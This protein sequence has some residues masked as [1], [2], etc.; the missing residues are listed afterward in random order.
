MKSG[1]AQLFHETALEPLPSHAAHDSHLGAT[2]DAGAVAS[3]LRRYSE[4]PNTFNSNRKEAERFLLWLSERRLT[5]DAI[6]V[7]DLLDYVAFLQAPE[8]AERWIGPSKPRYVGGEP[9]PLWRPF[10]GPLGASSVKLATTILFGLFEY[11]VTASYLRANLWRLLPKRKASRNRELERYLPHAARDAV[12]EY[13]R[14][15]VNQAEDGAEPRDFRNQWLIT[16]FY[17]SGA[18]RSE[19]ANARMSHVFRDDT[20]WWWKIYGKGG[21]IDEVPLSAEFIDQLTT[22]RLSVGLSPLPNPLEVS[23]PLV[24]DV[25][26]AQRP[27]GA[28]SVY[29]LIKEICLAASELASDPYVKATLQLASPHWLRHT[30]ASDQLNQAK[31]GLAAVSR[32]L[33]HSDIAIT[34]RY[35]HTDRATRHEETQRHI[36]P[37]TD[38]R[39]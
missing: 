8:P 23:I 36:L 35:L 5:L 25:Y 11:L 21:V 38:E 4:S 33:R 22:Y 12:F 26:G 16:V 28:S 3:W 15:R 1:F 24:G 30:A 17:L 2:D 27:L 34:S 7:E 6:R 31:L 13:V 29:K 10:S 32:N 18:R 14:D 37:S 20:G 9:N 39:D 19:V